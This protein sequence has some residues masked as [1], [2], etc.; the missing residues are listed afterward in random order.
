MTLR[1]FREFLAK[2]SLFAGDSWHVWWSTLL[3]AFGE[4]LSTKEADAFRR[5][6][7]RDPVFN[8]VF[9]EIAAFVGRRGGKDSASSIVLVYL[10]LLRKWK[11]S[12]GEIGV[13]LLL[14]VD[15]EQAKVAFKYVRGLLEAVPELES[16]VQSI[17]SDRIILKNGIEIQVGTSD[18]ASVRGRTVL[19]A[20]LDEA[21]FWPHDQLTEVLRAL[22][23]SMA[24][25]P[26]AM[27]L[28]ITTIYAANGPAY[29]V[30]RE[31]GKDDPRRL[32]VKGT[33]R[34]FNPTVSEEFIKAELDKDPHGAGAEYMTIPRSDL[35]TFLDAA[36]V[37]SATRSSPRELPFAVTNPQGGHYSYFAG[38]DVSGGR[39]DAAAA[40]VSRTDG[41]RVAVCATRRWPA[42][43]DPLEVAKQV[44]AF[45]KSYHLMSAT[46]DNYAA[47]FATASYREAGVHLQPADFSRSESYLYM[48]PLFTT[49]RIEI[50]DEPTL[51]TEL[52][53]LQRRTGRSGKDAVDHPPHGHDDLANATSLSAVMASRTTGSD[54]V[55]VHVIKSEFFDDYLGRGERGPF[56]L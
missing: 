18:Y 27:L 54:D 52:L 8:R 4:K 48:L 9:R 41:E 34:D 56:D 28:I 40:A 39:G 12:P 44:A 35:E 29:D 47:E 24:T 17:Q 31:W 19:A 26:D 49:G 33:T 10:A 46:A 53:G 30:F 50:P 3:G 43:H 42:P 14:A 20:V 7:N 2:R 13:V 23:P 45:L 5:A 6:T 32:V 37:D 11:L 22:R 36:L 16:E 55:H 25:Q 15:R 1:K 21:S 38:L 51:R